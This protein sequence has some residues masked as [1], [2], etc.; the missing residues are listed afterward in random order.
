MTSHT[1]DA[2]ATGRRN[3][4][5]EIVAASFGN[6]LEFYDL[7]IYG[8]FAVVIGRLF[9]PADNETTSLLLSVGSFGVSFLMRPLGAMVLGAYADRAGRK[10]SL[11]LS[12]GLMMIGTAMITFVPSYQSIGLAAPALILVARMLQG[13]S[14]GGEFGAATAFMV[15]HSGS[16]RRGFFASWQ[17]STQGLATVLAAG[18]SAL[19]SATLSDAQLNEWGW[20]VAFGLGLLIGPVGLYIR[21]Q[22]D[23]TPEFRA[24]AAQGRTERTPLREVL[25]QAPGR[26]LLAIGVVAGATAFNYVHK[27]YMPTYAIKQLQIPATS[28]FLGALVTGVSLMVLAPVFGGLSDRYGRFRVLTLAMLAIGLSSWPLFLWLNQSPTVGTL[29]MVQALVGML[30]AASLG[31]IPAMLSDIFPTRVRGTG[32]ALSYNFSVTLFGG[33]APLIVTW[34]IDASGNRMAPSGYVIATASISLAAVLLL[35]RRMRHATH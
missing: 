13:F 26:L 11:T 10:A 22:I 8:Y 4:W 28:S 25:V 32:L 3:P 27:L 31:P 21:A 2:P 1:L 17:L 24:E 20:R 19:L 34:L 6:A 30:I 7:L 35:G 15:E 16:D 14:T 12:I 5:K 23:E 9:F 18:V 33:F 29:L